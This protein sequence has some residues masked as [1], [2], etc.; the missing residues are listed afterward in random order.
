MFFRSVH[1]TLLMDSRAFSKIL[2][3]PTL[4]VLVAISARLGRQT[5]IVSKFHAAI[6]RLNQLVVFKF[7]LQ[8]GAAQ[9]HFMHLGV[10]WPLDLQ[11]VHFIKAILEPVPLLCLLASLDLEFS[12][13]QGFLPASEQVLQAPRHQMA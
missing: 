11:Q 1:F 4:A 7:Q 5:V 12:S 13:L 2:F 8:G 10:D 6:S 3:S 9:V